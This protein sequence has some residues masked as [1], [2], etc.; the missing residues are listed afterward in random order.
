MPQTSMGQDK[1]ILRKILLL[2]EKG[3]AER[4]KT[5]LLDVKIVG[6]IL[7]VAAIHVGLVELLTTVMHH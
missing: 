6:E 1:S 4:V 3:E 7:V 2:L 5:W